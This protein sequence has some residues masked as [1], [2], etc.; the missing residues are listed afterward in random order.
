LHRSRVILLVAALVTVG[1]LTGARDI[2]RDALTDLRFA[3]LSRPATGSI[4]VVAMD[5]RSIE[6]I[7]VWPWSR[8]LHAAVIGRLEQFGAT[9][10]VFDIDFSSRS[11]PAEDETF[12]VA[13]IADEEAYPLIALEQLGHLPL[14]HLVARVDDELARVVARQGHGHEGMP[15]GARASGDENGLVAEHGHFRGFAA[16]RP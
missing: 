5:A 3:M 16:V 10:I 2:L 11:A 15:E 7:G 14:L 1:L 12:A 4:A 8:R 13:H 6:A 9:D